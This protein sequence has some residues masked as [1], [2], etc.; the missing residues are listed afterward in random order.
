M[1]C[2]LFAPFVF[3]HQISRVKKTTRKPL[4]RYWCNI[5]LFLDICNAADIYDKV[6][7]MNTNELNTDFFCNED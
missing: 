4:Q 6:N 2:F 5:F 7:V 3:Q 1:E